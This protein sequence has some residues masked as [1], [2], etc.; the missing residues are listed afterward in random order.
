[1]NLFRAAMQPVSF[2]TSLVVARASISVMAKIFTGLAS[3][4]RL[5]M[6]NPS[7]FPEGTLKM[8]LVGLSFHR[9]LT[10]SGLDDHVIHVSLNIPTQLIREAHLD[11][12]LIGCSCI[13]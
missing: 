12:M 3:I 1:M 7:N 8:H 9:N 4:P 5:L 11:R 2:C 13:F 6:I 10:H